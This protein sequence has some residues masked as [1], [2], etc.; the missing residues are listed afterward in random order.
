LIFAA[1]YEAHRLERVR[2]R[3][4]HEESDIS[5]GLNITE[6]QIVESLLAIPAFIPITVCPGYLVAWFTNL[7]DFRQRSLVERIFWSLPLSLA[8]STISAYFIGKFVSVAAIVVLLWVAA[9]LTV[10]VVSQEWWTRRRSHAP[11]KIGW[12]P[13]GGRFATFAIIWVAVAITSLVDIQTNQKVFASLAIFDHSMRVNWIDSIVHSGIPPVNSLFMF[14]HPS[15][16][17]YYY[18]WYIL[19]AAIARMTHLPVRPLLNASCVW[20]G[21]NLVA[22]AGL[23]LKHFLKVGGRLRP[24]LLRGVGLL[25]V[26]N[27]GVCVNLWDFFVLHAS[28]PGYL[29]VWKVGEISSWFDSLLW[30]PHHVASMTCCMLGFLLA[31]MERKLSSRRSIAAVILIAASFASAFGLSIYVAFAF[32]LVCLAWALWQ[33]VFERSFRPALLLAAAGTG[34]VIL[35]LPFLAELTHSESTVVG[36]SVFSFAVRE[37]IPP[38]PLLAT[39]F[40]R[41]LAVDHVSAARNLANSILL[42]P[43]YAVE[44]GFYFVV[45][46]IFL[47]PA[48]RMRSPIT[49]AQR[50]LLFIGAATLLPMSFLRSGVI[51]SN[52]FGWRAALFLQFPLLLLASDLLTSWS[53]ADG[54]TPELIA[55]ESLPGKTPYL[56]RA[57]ASYALVLGVLTTLYQALMVRFTIPFREAQLRATRGSTAGWLPHKAFISAQGYAELNA[58]ISPNA[59]VQYNPRIPDQLWLNADWI[60]VE[61]SSAIAYDTPPCGSE[62]GGDPRGCT[63]VSPAIN[64]LYNGASAAQAR[65]TCREFA[66]QYLVA[67]IYDPAW[68]DQNSWVWNLKPVVADPEFRALD[69]R[70]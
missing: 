70:E 62:F 19:C 33:V 15:R 21:F 46:L 26:A 64:R 35:L 30:V 24:Q 53:V 3:P 50:S 54:K 47:V 2:N 16:M 63:I 18:F 9:V 68:N 45:F 27:V 34:A 11:W 56:I 17:R 29:E 22:L 14:I 44:L 65:S 4:R 66:I 25:A 41:Q 20:S 39:D 57:I 59:V 38:E 7:H 28:L 51:E 32:F 42:V 5:P 48:F 36:G 61:H 69:C 6:T 13:L 55:A 67:R 58:L 23:Y 49:A 12:Q 31:S 37:T 8:V 40:F 10:G 1:H 43:G 52:D 60:G